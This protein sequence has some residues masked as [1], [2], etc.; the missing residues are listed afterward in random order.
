ME[1]LEQLSS[2]PATGNV[3]SHASDHIGTMAVASKLT[4]VS[5]DVSNERAVY[6]SNQDD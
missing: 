5:A 4:T 6:L 1:G 2:Y 3:R